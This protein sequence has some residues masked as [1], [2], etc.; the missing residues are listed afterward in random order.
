MTK[1]YDA[2][3]VVGYAN[4]GKS[5]TVNL[6]F[7]EK[8][9]GWITLI[10]KKFFMRKMSNSDDPLSYELFIR[11]MSNSDDPKSYIKFIKNKSLRNLILTFNPDIDNELYFSKK[12]LELLSKAHNCYFYI[13]KNNFN[14]I[15]E[16][17]IIKEE[18]INFLYNFGQVKVVENIDKI[19]RGNGFKKFIIN[20]LLSKLMSGKV[21]INE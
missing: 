9:N 12:N 5:E 6:A 13:L 2:F 20:I 8:R 7:P 1:K 10:N 15:D 4:W 21:R 17:Q 18:H 16:K 11:K 3:I 14:K 19:E